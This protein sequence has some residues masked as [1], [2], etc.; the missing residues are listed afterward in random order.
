M[1]SITSCI[2]RKGAGINRPPRLP[3]HCKWSR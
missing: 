3:R 2:S 1:Y